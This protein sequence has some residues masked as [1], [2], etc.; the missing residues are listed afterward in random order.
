MGKN[1]WR[2]GSIDILFRAVGHGGDNLGIVLDKLLVN[3]IESE[4]GLNFFD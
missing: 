2:R 1:N 4:K 3:I